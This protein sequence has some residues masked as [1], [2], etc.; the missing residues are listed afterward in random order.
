MLYIT[1]LLV[2]SQESNKLQFKKEINSLFIISTIFDIRQMHHNGKHK[3]QVLS[4]VVAI[5]HMSLHLKFVQV[6]E[7]S[8]Y[9]N[10]MKHLATWQTFDLGELIIITMQTNYYYR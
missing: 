5:C 1:C 2:V 8:L 10:C 9:I 7:V 3:S 6:V 4:R